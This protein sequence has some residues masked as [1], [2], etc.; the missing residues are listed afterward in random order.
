[1]EQMTKY[2]PA[3]EVNTIKLDIR[4]LLYA[5]HTWGD[6]GN[7]P[8][9]LL[10]GWAD[11]GL[12]FQFLA[13]AM[14][15]N[16]YLIAPD[17]RGFGDSEWASQGYWFPDY[18][19]DLDALLDHFSPAETVKLLG[20]SMG[21]NVACLYA[22]I[23]P[24]RVSHLASIDVFGLPE[25]DPI[26]APDRYG[27]WLEQFKQGPAFSDYGDL[28]QLIEH[29][30]KLAPG[31]NT[32]RAHFIAET[33]SRSADNG[34]GFAIKADPAHKRVNPVLY[35]REE[36][37]ACWRN[38][39]ARALLLFGEDSRFCK[40]YYNDGYQQDCRECFSDLS[41]DTVAGAGHMI[42]LQQPETL[43]QKLQVFFN[44]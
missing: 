26:D 22:G 17:W 34:S 9:F 21:G 23:R 37:R 44:A 30:M 13:D 40:S 36:A 39:T 42:H 14:A 38:I 43:A 12:S 10:H 25:T 5:V 1:M 20:H 35:R 18:L 27:L 8:V 31:L 11:T 32:V 41:E 15:D 28:E 3:R 7:R 4:G 16:Y 33:W 29:I 6:P 19:A 2:I 24:H